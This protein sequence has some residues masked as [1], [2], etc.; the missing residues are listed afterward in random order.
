MYI[1]IYIYILDYISICL[2]MAAVTFVLRRVYVYYGAVWVK[3]RAVWI[4]IYTYTY[5]YTYI[6]I[7][8]FVMELF[9]Q[10]T[11]LFGYRTPRVNPRCDVHSTAP[12]PRR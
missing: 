10:R 1:Y 6:Y 3:D 4:Y 8:T 12:A 7:Y 11:E 9:G 2:F 5:I